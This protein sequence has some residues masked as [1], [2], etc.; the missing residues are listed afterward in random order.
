M[1][2]TVVQEI[3]E[4][5]NLLSD[6]DFK[7]WMLNNYDYLIKMEKIQSQNIPYQTCPKCNGD[8]NLLRYN[9]PVF[10]GTTQTPICDVCENKKII[11]M[12]KFNAI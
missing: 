9:S 7:S 4:K 5:F 10:L 1:N 11:P 8:G 6:A 12:F 3:F 2:K